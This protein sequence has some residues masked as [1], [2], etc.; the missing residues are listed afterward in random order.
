MTLNKVKGKTWAKCGMCGDDTHEV[1]III[2]EK[3]WRIESWTCKCG[4]TF[5]RLKPEF[6]FDDFDWSTL[7]DEICIEK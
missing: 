6:Y 5:P 4:N 7:V 2:T 3:T 1:I